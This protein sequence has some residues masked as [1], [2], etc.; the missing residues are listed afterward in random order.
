MILLNHFHVLA[1]SSGS[2]EPSSR[3]TEVSRQP[4]SSWR[5]WLYRPASFSRTKKPTALTEDQRWEHKRQSMEIEAAAYH[6]ASE[7]IRQTGGLQAALVEAE[8]QYQIYLQA[9][10]ILEKSNRQLRRAL[11]KTK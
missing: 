4:S 2:S 11:W 1:F 6:A 5:L 9:K 7:M 10:E 8:K 3:W